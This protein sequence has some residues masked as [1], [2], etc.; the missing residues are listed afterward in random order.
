MSGRS[1]STAEQTRPSP[2]R[3]WQ[4]AVALLAGDQLFEWL[5]SQIHPSATTALRNARWVVRA[6]RRTWT[7]HELRVQRWLLPHHLLVEAT[8]F[9]YGTV[10]FVVPPLVLVLLWRAFPARY[11][12]WRNTL[13]IA[14]ALGLVCFALYPLAPPR[15]LPSSFGFTDTMRVIGGLGPLDSSHFKDTNAFAAM[16]SLHLTWSTWCAC[17]AASV[18]QRRWVKLAVF[19]Y[20]AIT[21]FVV[22]ATANH[23][24]LDAVGGWV[25]L[26]LG[27]VIAGRLD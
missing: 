11:A 5:R 17:A 2:L 13:I 27:W 3:W 18:A 23:F 22:M 7:F 12:R 24:F 9:Y 8:D 20:P 10:H 4:E 14:T 6:E 25:V 21:L 19:A 26:G 16:P 1:L 15:L